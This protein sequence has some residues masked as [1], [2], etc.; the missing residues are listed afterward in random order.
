MML[1]LLLGTASLHLSAH[2]LWIESNSSGKSGKEHTV[3]VFYGEPAAGVPDKIEDWWSDVSSFTLWLVKPDGSKEQLKVSNQGDHFSA[4]FTPS[5][6]GLYTLSVS[7]NVAEISG[8]TLYQFNATAL[9]RVGDALA[10]SDYASG[11]NELYLYADP[12]AKSG[13]GK[14]LSV[15][16]HSP[17]GPVAEAYV[18]AFAPSGWSKSFQADASGKGSFTPEWT[19]TYLIEAGKGDEV[20]GKPYENIYRIATLQVAVPR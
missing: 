15:S 7:H 12:A 5:A 17:E 14:T 20:T 19:G 2:A 8:G 3:K 16:C 4:A 1:L 13:K 6:D 18:T 9:V 10:S 11:T